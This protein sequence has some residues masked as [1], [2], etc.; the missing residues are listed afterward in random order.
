MGGPTLNDLQ[1]LTPDP[2][3]RRQRTPR[4]IEM[5][6]A[7]LREVGAGRSIVIDETG[8]V[9]AGNGVVEAAAAAGMQKVQIV[10]ADGQTIIA[11]RRSGLTPEQKRAMAL[12]DNR[13]AE[14]AAW[15]A[16]QLRNDRDMGLDLSPFF[17][18]SEEATLL[19]VPVD[20]HAWGGMP[21]FE[22][23]DADGFRTITIHFA[24]EAAVKAFEA[25]VGPL[26]EKAH[27]M[28]FPR[29]ELL[30]PPIPVIYEAE[31]AS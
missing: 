1:D 13:T 28:W 27:G 15:D 19:G 24:D 20:G 10:D 7:S 9:I 8:E 11:V 3:N 2:Q 21:E 30:N 23:K 31:D 14:L 16:E 12:Y 4:N 18:E 25:L 6:T 17:T 26:P 22:Q 5:L 29:G